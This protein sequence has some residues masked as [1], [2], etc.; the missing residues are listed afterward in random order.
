MKR[1]R[2][3]IKAITMIELGIAGVLLLLLVLLVYWYVDGLSAYKPK[4]E[5]HQFFGGVLLEYE[6]DAT[7]RENDGSLTV[8]T[9]D[10]KASVVNSPMLYKGSTKMTLPCDMILFTPAEN[11]NLYRINRFTTVSESSGRITYQSGKKQ[12]QSYG[13]FLYDGSDLYVFLE[14]TTLTIGTMSVE[15]PAMSYAKVV[16]NDCVEYHNS[17]TDENKIVAVNDVEITAYC[18]GGYLLNPG[19]DVMYKDG[20]EALIFS[21]VDKVNVIEMN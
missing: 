16:Y 2:K 19:K 5:V 17:V 8:S 14:D 11:N 1:R 3:S 7:F 4:S 21:I 18:K 6:E 10:Y 9:K 12:A 20:N 15:L 13:G